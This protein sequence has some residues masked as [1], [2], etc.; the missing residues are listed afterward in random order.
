M[1]TSIRYVVAALVLSAVALSSPAEEELKGRDIVTKGTVQNLSGTL[2]ADGHEWA[3]STTGGDYELHLGPEEYRQS[4][5]LALTDGEPAEVR[6]FVFGKHVSPI[7]LKTGTAE[8]A[9][10]T[11]EGKSVWAG[12]RYASQKSKEK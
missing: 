11:E 4:K 1:K 8:C 3:L 6:G 12:T 9:F 10:R 7:S 2:K 5:G